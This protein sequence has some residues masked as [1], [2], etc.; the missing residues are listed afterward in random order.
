M[1]AF[2]SFFRESN[3]F[4]KEICRVDLTKKIALIDFSSLG[5]SVST[6]EMT[7]FR[8]IILL[9]RVNFRSIFLSSWLTP[10]FCTLMGGNT[11]PLLPLIR[12]SNYE[13]NEGLRKV[14]LKFFPILG[15]VVVSRVETQLISRNIFCLRQYYRSFTNFCVYPLLTPFITSNWLF[16][17]F[18]VA[19]YTYEWGCSFA[20]NDFYHKCTEL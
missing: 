1:I 2:C 6:L 9:V 19:E 14:R 13:I 7:I 17:E 16:P 15:E 18:C 12:V 8:E 5:C 11:C 10:D 20:F 3:V 4:T